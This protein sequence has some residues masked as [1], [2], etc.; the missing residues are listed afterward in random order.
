MA[1]QSV[2]IRAAWIGFSGGVLAAVIAGIVVI[3]RPDNSAVSPQ[4]IGDFKSN[5]IST[6]GEHSPVILNLQ[7]I[8]NVFPTVV[9][10]NQMQ[11]LMVVTNVVYKD[12][13]PDAL[14]EKQLAQIRAFGDRRGVEVTIPSNRV[15]KIKTPRRAFDLSARLTSAYNAGEMCTAYAIACEGTNLYCNMVCPYEKELIMVEGEFL[16]IASF[17]YSVLAEYSMYKKDYT[18]ALQLIRHA[19]DI[20]NE[21]NAF[22]IAMQAA[23]FQLNGEDNE[24]GA[25]LGFVRDSYPEETRYAVLNTVTKMGYLL[26]YRLKETA[27]G[28]YDIQPYN[29]L[30]HDFKLS[31]E[32]EF[33][34]IFQIQAGSVASNPTIMRLVGL[35]Q[36]EPVDLAS[37]FKSV[38]EKLE[39]DAACKR[40]N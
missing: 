10:T 24:M 23:L 28:R 2:T 34:L 8:Q 30:S 16:S 32:L 38:I 39:Q 18:N 21:T 33:P 7:N 15:A 35:N 37:H 20:S 19:Q 4:S 3:C 12:I 26:P 25:L 36:Y 22:H 14:D 5:A 1:K 6:K 13:E 11:N 40:A 9:F 29:Q 31:K 17:S 27:K